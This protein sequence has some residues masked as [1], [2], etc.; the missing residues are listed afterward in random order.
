LSTSITPGPSPGLV[1]F[2]VMVLELPSGD[3]M[4]TC[5]KLVASVHRVISM[6]PPT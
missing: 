5:R 4:V 3:V 1:R 6:R 2:S